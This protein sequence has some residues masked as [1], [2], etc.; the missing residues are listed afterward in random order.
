MHIWRAV[1]VYFFLLFHRVSF[2]TEHVVWWNRCT[3]FDEALNAH[4]TM[5][6]FRSS[7]T[8]KR[9]RNFET[10]SI[11][12]SF[13][14]SNRNRHSETTSIS[15]VDLEA[16]PFGMQFQNHKYLS[17]WSWA[18]T[19]R[20]AMKT[21]DLSHML[22]II[23]V[24]SDLATMNQHVS[25]ITCQYKLRSFLSSFVCLCASAA[26]ALNPWCDTKKW[27]APVIRR[28]PLSSVWTPSTYFVTLVS[29]QRSGQRP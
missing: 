1:H 12:S 23:I 19:I 28:C 10:T 17:C 25:Y 26:L 3:S 15:A 18:K 8:T 27:A 2:C 14:T 29:T 9:N 22:C 16:K 7:S 6:V 13:S 24:S 11:S 5:K 20:N 4:L 21:M